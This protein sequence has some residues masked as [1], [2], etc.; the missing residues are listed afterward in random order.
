MRAS[1]TSAVVAA[2]INAEIDFPWVGGISAGSSCTANYLGRSPERARQS[3]VDLAAD[4]EFGSWRTWLQ[5]KGRFHAEY[6]YEKTGLP[7][8]A[9]PYDWDAFNAHPAQFAIGALQARTGRM[10]YWGRDEVRELGDLMVRVRASSTLPVLMPPVSIDGEV[11]FDGALGPTGGFALDAAR[12][13][14]YERFVVIMTRPRNYVKPAAKL[15]SSAATRALFRRYPAVVDSILK[16]PRRYNHSRA[17]LFE[18]ERQGKAF[19]FCP[20]G[21][22]VSNSETDLR[23]LQR[24]YA[25][26]EAHIARELPALREFVGLPAN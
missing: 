18:L 6:I 10:Q 1:Y 20:E 15:V 12:A 7:G 16:R 26:G 22:T 13:A 14:G 9:L 11:Y 17:E 21:L 2:L 4:P 5:G 23:K 19:L 3:F 24:M 8:A 25:L